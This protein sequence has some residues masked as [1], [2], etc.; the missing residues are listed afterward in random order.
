MPPD[1]DEKIGFVCPAPIKPKITF[2]GENLPE[3]FLELYR[4]IEKKEIDL[5]IVMGTALAVGPFNS[6]VDLVECPAVLINL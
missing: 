1:A 4:E 5:M 3:K 2:F 6:V